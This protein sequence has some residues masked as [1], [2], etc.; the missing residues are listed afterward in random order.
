MGSKDYLKLTCNTNPLKLKWFVNATVRHNL[1]VHKG[2]NREVIARV[3]GVPSKSVVVSRAVHSIPEL[4]FARCQNKTEKVVSYRLCS[5][6]KPPQ[7]L[8]SE[9]AK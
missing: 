9:Y 5:D 8:Q 4:P 1:L 7:N 2:Q 6:F 3:A